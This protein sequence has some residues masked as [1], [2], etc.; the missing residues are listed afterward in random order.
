MADCSLP[1]AFEL[2]VEFP[3]WFVSVPNLHFLPES[4]NLECF[5]R[6]GVISGTAESWGLE[7]HMAHA[8]G[9]ETRMHTAAS[10]AASSETRAAGR[11]ADSRAAC[12]ASG[13]TWPKGRAANSSQTSLENSSTPDLPRSRGSLLL[14]CFPETLLSWTPSSWAS[15]SSQLPHGSPAQMNFLCK[16]LVGFQAMEIFHPAEWPWHSLSFLVQISRQLDLAPSATAGPLGS[17][18][19]APPSLVK[20]NALEE[21]KQWL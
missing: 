1:T 16:K 15:V 5:Q 7:Q 10:T 13:A 2:E 17:E 11:E 18:G 20:A 21:M 4:R 6:P 9:P 19:K 14:F 8:Y 3:H 12:G